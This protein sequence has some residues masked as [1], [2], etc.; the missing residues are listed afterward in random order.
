VRFRDQG[1]EAM[2]NSLLVAMSR[3]VTLERQMD[4]VANNIANLGTAGFKANSSVF[5]EFLNTVAQEN[6]FPPADAPVH[7]VFDRTAYKNLGQGPVQ[8]TGNPLDV[9]IS[10]DGFLSVQTAAGERYTRNGGF[11][12]NA[13]GQLVTVDGAIVNGD[14]GPIVFQ[15]NDRNISISADGRIG[16]LEGLTNTETQRGKLKLVTF[17]QPQRLQNEG[18]NQFSAPAGLAAQPASAAVTVI[19]GAVEGSNVSGVREMTRMIE[20]NRT[21]SLIAAIMQTQGDTKTIDRLADV[22]A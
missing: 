6:D 11:M 9:A 5:G 10:G 8:Q 3:Q 18:A 7:F 15:A 17:A 21:Y 4:V 20:I 13:A 1:N 22:P 2:D 12:I 16:V 14:N 19:Q